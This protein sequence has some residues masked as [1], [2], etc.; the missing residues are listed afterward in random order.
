[1]N[2]LLVAEDLHT[3]NEWLIERTSQQ[4]VCTQGL[5]RHLEGMVAGIYVKIQSRF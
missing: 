5:Y 1:M 3:V 2:D 4:R